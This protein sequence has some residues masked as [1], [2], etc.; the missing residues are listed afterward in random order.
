[1]KKLLLTTICGA[2]CD[3]CHS[4]ASVWA[5]QSNYMCFFNKSGPHLVCEHCTVAIPV[6]ALVPSVSSYS[7]CNIY[8]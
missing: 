5:L 8:T 6:C 3:H 2:M 7:T 4:S 1:M